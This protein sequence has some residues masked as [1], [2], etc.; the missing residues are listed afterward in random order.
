M[1]GRVDRVQAS[2]RLLGQV[3]PGMSHADAVV[4]VGAAQAHA[5]LALAEQQRIA[6]LIALGQFRI[7][8][9]EAPMFRH[10]VGEPTSDLDVA[11][12]AE[13]REALGL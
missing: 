2:Q 8:P 7:D 6:N 1:S 13:I 5:T 4:A 10:L 3:T 9:N 11:P 12:A